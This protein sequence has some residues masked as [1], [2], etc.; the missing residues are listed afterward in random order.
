MLTGDQGAPAEA[1]HKAMADLPEATLATLHNY[2]AHPRA[3]ILT[4]RADAVGTA[5]LTFLARQ[6]Q[7]R[8][9]QLSWWT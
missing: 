9:V 6:E 1:V 8:A 7:A 2:F 4:D 5:M 3:D